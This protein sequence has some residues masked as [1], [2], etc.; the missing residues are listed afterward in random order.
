MNCPTCG[1]RQIAPANVEGYPVKVDYCSA[2]EGIWLDAGESELLLSTPERAMR[3][4]RGAAP[5]HRICPKC[6]RP[7]HSFYYP[8]TFVTVDMCNRCHGLWL[9]KNEFQEIDRVRTFVGKA[10][11]IPADA[12]EAPRHTL[13][14]R[15]LEFID[16]E[17]SAF[18]LW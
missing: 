4:P 11:I 10:R 18:K 2:C 12:A 3:V 9:D 5:A 14:S 17:I 8:K 7:M 16:D 13:K 6:I 15:L 1:D